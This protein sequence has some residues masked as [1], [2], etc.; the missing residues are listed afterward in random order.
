M[1]NKQLERAN[2]EAVHMVESAFASTTR[3][4]LREDDVK[5]IK[6]TREQ[7]KVCTILYIMDGPQEETNK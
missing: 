4:G 6:W 7:G 1:A 3:C 5:G 2:A